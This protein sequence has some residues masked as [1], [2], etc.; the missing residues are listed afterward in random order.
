MGWLLIAGKALDLAETIRQLNS[1]AAFAAPQDPPPPLNKFAAIRAVL[2]EGGLFD[3]V[4]DVQLE[5]GKA[6]NLLDLVAIL[7]LEDAAWNKIETVVTQL[8]SIGIEPMGFRALVATAREA[9]SQMPDKYYPLLR[10]VD[11]FQE[12]SPGEN[13]GLVSWTAAAAAADNPDLANGIAIELTA[14]GSAA[15]EFE[16]GHLF[17]NP[18]PE[19]RYLR[20]GVTGAVDTSASASLPLQ[21]GTIAVSSGA[22]GRFSASYMSRRQTD[23]GTFALETAQAIPNLVNP[24]SLAPLYKAMTRGSLHAMTLSM[25]GQAFMNTAVG[26][27]RSIDIARLVAVSG[28]LTVDAEVRLGGSYDVQVVSAG[29]GTIEVTVNSSAFGSRTAGSTLAVTL[30]A[31]QL[32]E[33]VKGQIDTALTEARQAFARIE[34][35]LQPGK[36]LKVMIGA[37]IKTHFEDETVQAL[38][39]LAV[40]QASTPAA[41]KA[42]EGLI[43]GFLDS[44]VAAWEDPVNAAVEK[45]YAW[46]VQRFPGLIHPLL[47]PMLKLTLAEALKGANEQLEQQ[48]RALSANKTDQLLAVLEKSGVAVSQQLDAVDAAVAA[49]RNAIANHVKHVEGILAKAEEVAASDLK[50]QLSS[51]VTSSSGQSLLARASITADSAASRKAYHSLV[52][53]NLN[54]IFGLIDQ[55]VPGV[56]VELEEWQR[57]AEYRKQGGI[58]LVFMDLE[59]TAET[60]FSS[61]ATV[62]VDRTGALSVLTNA[63]WARRRRGFGKQREFLFT[64]VYSLIAA[65][66]TRSFRTSLSLTHSDDDLTG[67]EVAA[68]LSR[69]DAHGLIHP[70]VIPS[71]LSHMR[72]EEFD[73]TI[74]IEMELNHEAMKRLLFLNTSGPKLEKY[75]TATLVL[76][77]LRKAGQLS[78]QN[79]EL[80]MACL[81]KVGFGFKSSM[82]PEE[83]LLHLGNR[84]RQRRALSQYTGSSTKVAAVEAWVDAYYKA[85][86][87][88]K[89]LSSMRRIYNADPLPGNTSKSRIEKWYRKQQKPIDD[90]LERWVVIKGN[91][92]EWISDDMSNQTLAFLLA[93]DSLTD[94]SGTGDYPVK[95]YLKLPSGPRKLLPEG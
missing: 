43:A 55:P 92:L 27:S 69:L 2:L 1:L 49:T 5:L 54:E 61:K 11:A 64:S 68:L 4:E 71:A 70:Q 38:A 81:R 59:L 60:V 50:M 73:A 57:F 21:A 74:S 45:G 26:L 6:V 32:A 13:P 34:V 15:L 19:S 40:G 58:S 35:F 33:H 46:I 39:K 90:A 29:E 18:D 25:N 37:R 83:L 87:L 10:H 16:A 66:L 80:G 77:S 3:A 17:P 88:H 76:E 12:R 9:L 22:E 42:I 53:G 84:Q 48:V 44:Q 41:R 7:A 14:Q 79:Y 95:A 51:R 67:G 62:R 93:I 8:E 24:L 31:S 82:T 36:L 30:N 47:V 94:P 28:A 75:G 91:L 86:A 78:L 85:D 56:S 23:Y 89:M 20:I 52:S 63:E 72:E 65:R